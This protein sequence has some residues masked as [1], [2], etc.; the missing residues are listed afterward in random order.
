MQHNTSNFADPGVCI[1]YV[2]ITFM[3]RNYKLQAFW[4][5][6][7]YCMEQGACWEVNR[8]AAS[9]EIPRILWNPK[10]H[11]RIHKCPAP[12][13]ILSQLNPTS[14][15]SISILY[16]PHTPGSP[17]WSISLRIPHQNPAH[18]SPHPIR[19][20]CPVHLIILDFITL[21]ILGKE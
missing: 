21:T 6:Y 11:Y 7:T 1:N 4:I 17:Q 5:I 20:I 14:W 9:Q 16:L 15:R 19:A 3:I 12:V 13:P 2:E 10:V 8:F 18:A